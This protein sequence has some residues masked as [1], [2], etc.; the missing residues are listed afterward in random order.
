[1]FYVFQEGKKPGPNAPSFPTGDEAIKK[2]QEMASE[3]VGKKYLVFK[4]FKSF[5]SE[6]P[7]VTSEDIQ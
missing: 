7:K 5:V 2:A 4:A 1:M 3:H 6:K